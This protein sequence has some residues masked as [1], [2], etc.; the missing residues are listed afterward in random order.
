MGPAFQ[1][2]PPGTLD[3]TSI[4]P[5]RSRTAD[6]ARQTATNAN[7]HLLEGKGEPMQVKI[8]VQFEVE[9]DEDDELTEQQAKDAASLAAFHHL[10]LIEVSGVT[11]DT[12]E[13]EVHVDGF[14]K[15]RVRL[16]NDEPY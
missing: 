16:S 4:A 8:E 1:D 6:S 10:T 5:Q 12:E 13:V 15:C 14:G 11:T 3:P 9:T 7:K 2:L